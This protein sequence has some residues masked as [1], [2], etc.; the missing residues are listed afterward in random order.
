MLLLTALL[1]GAGCGGPDAGAGRATGP[2]QGDAAAASPDA[3]QRRPA[4]VAMA[5]SQPPP[6]RSAAPSVRT[7][8]EAGPPVQDAF[9]ARGWTPRAASAAAPKPVASASA[10]AAPAS[11]PTPP[12]RL[13]YTLVGRI[14]EQGETP[15]YIFERGPRVVSVRAGQWLDSQHRLE[16]ASA[17]ELTIVQVPGDLRFTVRIGP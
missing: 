2:G 3:S 1:A 5:A 16:S 11:A 8:G 14:T 17:T 9:A 4:A 13:A 15:V 10:P 6:L 12:P 7:V